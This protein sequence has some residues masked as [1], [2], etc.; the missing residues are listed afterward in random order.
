[1]A[2]TLFGVVEY[3]VHAVHAVALGT[4]LITVRDLTAVCAPCAQRVTEPDEAA[5]MRHND[6]VMIFAA[7]GPILP[8]PVGVAFRNR[9]GVERWLE[10]HYSALSDALSFVQN[11]VAA[12]VHVTRPV[13]GEERETSADLVAIASESM[14]ELRASAVATVALR[15]DQKPGIVQSAAFLVEANAWPQ[16]AAAVEASGRQSTSVR[17]ELTGPW[18]P[19]DFV[20]MQL[21]T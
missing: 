8:A 11:R 13:A 7:G 20:Q 15:P 2:L 12:R 16:F 18:P 19:Y 14:R 17:F 6:V 10:L 3:D 1:M 9:E 21:G 5:A 4:E